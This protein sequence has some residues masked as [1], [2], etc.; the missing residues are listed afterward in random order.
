MRLRNQLFS[1]A[2]AAASLLAGGTAH[3]APDDA[4]LAALTELSLELADIGATEGEA[5]A[6]GPVRFVHGN[7]VWQPGRQYAQG[8]GWLALACED[9][10]CAL[11]PAALSVTAKSWKGHYDERPT[12]GQQLDFQLEGGASKA[13]Q[14]V[15]WFAPRQTAAF[16]KPGEVAS[17]RVS[18]STMGGSFESVVRTPDGEARFVP[19]LWST[20][21]W[22]P[23]ERLQ[24]ERLGAPALLLQLRV[25][26]K[27]QLLPGLLATCSGHLR[28]TQYLLWAGDL[29]RDGMPDFMVSYID[30]AGPVHLYLSS[31]AKPGRLVGLAGVHHS[32]PLEG[33]CDGNELAGR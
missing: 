17:Y 29:D 7:Q 23:S 5:S 26:Q 8:S 14:V 21:Q 1:L 20:K 10:R 16:L 3:A 13:V 33:E 30:G 31:L 4:A 25:G 27:R 28:G 12:K 11:R 19:L 15:A 2:I 18:R 22:P 6:G 9:T 24:L 32:A